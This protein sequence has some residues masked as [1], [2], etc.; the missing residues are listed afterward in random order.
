MTYQLVDKNEKD[1]G[2]RPTLL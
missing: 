2:Y 1:C